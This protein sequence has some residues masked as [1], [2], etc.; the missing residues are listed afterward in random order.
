MTTQS[1][2]YVP[3]VLGRH[4]ADFL[5]EHAHNVVELAL[6]PAPGLLLLA[7]VTRRKLRAANR[8]NVEAAAGVH[9][10]AGVRRAGGRE[11][12]SG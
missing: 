3:L 6:Q 9:G 5:V 12:L 8:D 4:V 7:T 1:S 2:Y 11:R 10:R